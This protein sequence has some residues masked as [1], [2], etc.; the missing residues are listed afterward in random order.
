MPAARDK[1]TVIVAAV[2]KEINKIETRLRLVFAGLRAGLVFGRKNPSA[3]KLQK[4]STKRMEILNRYSK[5]KERIL[6]SLCV[7]QR[8]WDCIFQASKIGL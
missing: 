4:K 6:R 3:K 7:S 2:A 8:Q 5:I 1:E